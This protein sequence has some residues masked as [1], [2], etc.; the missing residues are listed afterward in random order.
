M[1]KAGFYFLIAVSGVIEKILNCCNK[2]IFQIK[3]VL[4][5]AI[6]TLLRYS[7]RKIYDGL[8]YVTSN[9]LF[10]ENQE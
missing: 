1:H 9:G 7:N 10:S 4:F 2:L 6:M 5:S 3:F 8:H